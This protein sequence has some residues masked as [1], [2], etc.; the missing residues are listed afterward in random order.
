MRL[1]IDWKT[2]NLVLDK[3]NKEEVIVEVSLIATK[4]FYGESNKLF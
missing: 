4:D 3:V 1:L 2:I